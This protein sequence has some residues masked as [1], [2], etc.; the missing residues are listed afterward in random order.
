MSFSLN[1]RNINLE[2]RNQE[3]ILLII[4]RYFVNE[5]QDKL[6]EIL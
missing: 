4:R 5:S 3:K 6:K 1:K 2:S